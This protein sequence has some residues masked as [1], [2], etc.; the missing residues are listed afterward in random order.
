V[1]GIEFGQVAKS[2][3]EGEFKDTIDAKPYDFLIVTLALL[4]RS[5][6]TPLES[7]F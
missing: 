2:V 4:F 3:I 1:G 6:T 7:S 5:S